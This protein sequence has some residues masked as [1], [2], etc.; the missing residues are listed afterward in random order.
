MGGWDT[1]RLKSRREAYRYTGS[2]HCWAGDIHQNRITPTDIRAFLCTHLSALEDLSISYY[3]WCSP[4]ALPSSLTFGLDLAVPTANVLTGCAPSAIR[5]PLR[6]HYF[7]RRWRQRNGDGETK[8]KRQEFVWQRRLRSPT[9]NLER[10]SL[11]HLRSRSFFPP[12]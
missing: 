2:N 10:G 5:L 7:K 4:P 12:H 1:S 11:I 9:H 3:G 8:T 6:V